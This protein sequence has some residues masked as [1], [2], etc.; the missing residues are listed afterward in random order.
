MRKDS[1]PQTEREP[2][3]SRVCH[4]CATAL[5]G[6]PPA[7]GKRLLC[8]ACAGQA[9]LE[10]RAEQR[11]LEAFADSVVVTTSPGVN[12]CRV[13]RQIGQ[14]RIEL[15]TEGGLIS[16]FTAEFFSLL[17]QR[18][19]DTHGQLRSKHHPAIRALT[20]RAAQKGAN[21]VLNVRL[22]YEGHAGERARYILSGTLVLLV[23]HLP[24][25]PHPA[26]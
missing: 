8:P 7:E 12:R 18:A 4:Q 22:V 11:R 1:G 26:P 5:P 2:M 20:L 23:P 3:P 17:G 19:E 16:E 10:A 9:A 21:A 25:I 14:E 15:I 6:G 24:D 13:E